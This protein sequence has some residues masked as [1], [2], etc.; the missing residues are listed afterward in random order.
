[1][2]RLVLLENGFAD[3]CGEK[4]HHIVIKDIIV[5]FD[6]RLRRVDKRDGFIFLARKIVAPDSSET[7]PKR[8][9][10]V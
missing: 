9:N 8:L 5:V 2:Q 4:G 10:G 7:S 6:K 3:Q 1:M